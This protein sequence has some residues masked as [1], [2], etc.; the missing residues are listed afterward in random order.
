LFE[1][2]DGWIAGIIDEAAGSRLELGVAARRP[3]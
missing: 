2:Y 3:E 1:G